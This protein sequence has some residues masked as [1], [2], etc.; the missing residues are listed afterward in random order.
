VSQNITLLEIRSLQIQLARLAWA[1][2]PMTVVLIVR[3]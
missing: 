2:N 3:E 1:P